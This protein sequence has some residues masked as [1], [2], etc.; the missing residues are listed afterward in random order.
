[1][2]QQWYKTNLIVKTLAM[3][4]PTQIPQQLLEQSI[5]MNEMTNTFSFRLLYW[6]FQL[7]LKWM[8]KGTC[9][10]K[11]LCHTIIIH[12]SLQWQPSSK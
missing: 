11:E 7:I 12:H 2:S 9:D 3:E 6:H 1:M 10:L 4:D 5:F 8:L